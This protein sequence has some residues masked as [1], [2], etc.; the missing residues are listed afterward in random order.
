M[1]E[2]TSPDFKMLNQ[3]ISATIVFEYEPISGYGARIMEPSHK[4][5]NFERIFIL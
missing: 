4:T 5:T 3:S 1:Q 2:G